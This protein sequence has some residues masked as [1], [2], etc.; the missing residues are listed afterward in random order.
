MASSS[1]ATAAVTCGSP[2][3]SRVRPSLWCWIA[4]QLWRNQR[5]SSTVYPLEPWRVLSCGSGRLKI[6][7]APPSLH[8]PL[9]LGRRE[10]AGG[11]VAAARVVE[12]GEGEPGRD[13]DAASARVAK[14]CLWTN[15]TLSTLLNDSDTAL[16]RAEPTR[17]MLWTTA[18]ADNVVRAGQ[19]ARWY[20]WM[21]PPSRSCRRTSRAVMCRG[22][23]IGVGTARSGAAC[24]IAW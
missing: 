12:V 18:P 19:A 8:D 4:S 10:A 7:G 24:C 16:S 15:S 17:P 2:C 23:V 14:D 11:A 9:E 1:L 6:V 13:A 3:A 21:M 20:S 5:L 22:S